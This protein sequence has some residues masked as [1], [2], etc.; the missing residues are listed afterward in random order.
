MRVMLSVIMNEF[1]NG[2]MF[3][4]SFRVGATTNA[5]VGF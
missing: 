5:E 4:P 3:Y 1:G 2:K